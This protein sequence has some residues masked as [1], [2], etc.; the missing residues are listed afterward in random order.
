MNKELHYLVREIFKAPNIFPELGFSEVESKVLFQITQGIPIEQIGVTLN[1]SVV[2]VRK[3]K[4]RCLPLI[5]IFIRQK[6]GLLNHVNIAT[7]YTQLEKFN[8]E[9]EAIMDYC[10]SLNVYN[11]RELGLS[12]RTK[13][14][15]QAYGIRNT[16]D[17][18]S[19]SKT[20]LLEVK[21]IGGIGIKELEKELFRLNL[22]FKKESI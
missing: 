2:E 22:Q 11:I 21:N 12:K 10:Q 15:L 20:E 14:A 17:L 9:I 8:K 6:L 7:I 13:N 3:L 16:T 5:P 1:L 19:Y 4:F 18:V